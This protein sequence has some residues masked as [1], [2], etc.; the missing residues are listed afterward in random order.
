MSFVRSS[1]PLVMATIA[2]L[3]VV[4]PAPAQDSIPS[5]LERTGTFR[6]RKVRESSGLAV[7][8]SHPG[9]LWTHNDSGDGPFIYAVNISGDLLGVF[10]VRGAKAEDWEDLSLAP[11]PS[12]PGSCLYLA[13]IGDNPQ[14]R[15]SVRLYI[16]PEPDPPAASPWQDTLETAPARQL[17]V[18]YPDRPHD[19]EALFV[20]RERRANIVTKGRSG[21]IRRFVVPR[22]A[23]RGDSTT[24]IFVDTLPITPQRT[25]GRLVTGAAISPS[26]RRVVVRTYSELYFFRRSPTGSLRL[27]GRPCW[28]GAVEPQGEAVDFLDEETVA[29]TSESLGNEDGTLLEVRCS[30]ASDAKP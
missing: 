15:K 3:S 2:A 22:A 7:S 28:I 24:A 23:F 1:V 16:V 6:T 9:V 21:P 10:R 29:L 26:G 12:G 17:I 11:C 20:D 25:L 13:D 27:D 8:R 4:R 18:T 14:K 30:H 19:A 5:L